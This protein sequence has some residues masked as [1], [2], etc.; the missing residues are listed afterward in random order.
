MILQYILLVHFLI[1]F[2]QPL[3]PGMSHDY[4]LTLYYTI[5]ELP[6]LL[7]QTQCNSEVGVH[8]GGSPHVYIHNPKPAAC[9][10]FHV[11]T[12]RSGQLVTYTFRNLII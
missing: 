5:V 3:I 1:A 4:Q 9:N 8:F 11:R 10:E 6:L 12:L 7:F 2:L